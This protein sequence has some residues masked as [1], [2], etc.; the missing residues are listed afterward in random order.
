MNTPEQF[1]NAAEQWLRNHRFSSD[2]QALTK[3]AQRVRE[4]LD[5]LGGYVSASSYERAYLELTASGAIKPFRGTVDEHV[6]AETP[7]I[8]ADIVSWIENPRVSAFE[9][10]RRYSTDPQFKRYYDLYANQQL[11][12]KIAQESSGSTLTVEEYRK[13]PAATVAK[14]YHSDRNFRAGVD[15]LIA[16]GRI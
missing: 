16:E 10:R 13:L 7:A 5:K 12:Q 8:P 2:P 1:D 3:I 11:K 14:R 4:N 15:A 9:Q 6:A